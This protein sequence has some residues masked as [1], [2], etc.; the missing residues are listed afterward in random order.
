MNK[1]RKNARKISKTRK[2]RGGT[3]YYLGT[4]KSTYGLKDGELNKNITEGK[5]NKLG[6]DFKK[7]FFN[8][9][10]IKNVSSQPNKDPNYTHMSYLYVT[11]E[12][13]Y[14]F[15]SFEWFIEHYLE[16]NVL[17][18]LKKNN[19]YGVNLNKAIKIHNFT[20]D[21]VQSPNNKENDKYILR[22]DIYVNNVVSLN[23]GISKKM[24]KLPTEVESNIN[25]FIFDKNSPTKK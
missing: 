16:Q 19:K 12:N 2:S 6:E 17:P 22:G 8:A 21:M 10:S 5:L 7:P 23:K 25:E 20:I 18:E 15:I 11:C 14:D 4:I 9:C 3:Q 1:S 24:T 13:P